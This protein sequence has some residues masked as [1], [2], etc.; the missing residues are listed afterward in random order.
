[1]NR[2]L[3]KYGNNTITR[4]DIVGSFFVNLFYNEFYKK[5]NNIKQQRLDKSTTDIYVE[6]L[7]SYSDFT[8]REEFF[9]QAVNGIHAYV[10]SNT[11]QIDMTHKECIDF[12]VKEFIPENIFNNLRE[13]QKAKI[14]H[15]SI[16][17]TVKLFIS[18]IVS[19][20]I[21]LVIDNRHSPESSTIL[22]NEFLDIICIEKDKIYGKFIAPKSSNSIP[23]E[24]HK[25]KI[26]ELLNILNQKDKELNKKESLMQCLKKVNEKS[27]EIIKQLQ[28]QIQKMS[29]EAEINNL[30]KTNNIL[31]EEYKKE[32]NSLLIHT[33]LISRNNSNYSIS[34][35]SD[36]SINSNSSSKKGSKEEPEV[37]KI[38]KKVSKS[39]ESNE[40]VNGESLLYD[41]G[42]DYY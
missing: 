23:I 10:I 40:D 22:Q 17:T 1:M 26:T 31:D 25:K 39:L 34:N 29:K 20:Y 15:D 18:K 27:S 3:S 28:K 30:V 21:K 37:Y 6:L 2:H 11:N 9:K 12:I 19:R 16:K 14:F 38:E 41:T 33:N 36:I 32:N 8:E 24:I 35:D 7:S 13:N 42:D 5:S 4:F